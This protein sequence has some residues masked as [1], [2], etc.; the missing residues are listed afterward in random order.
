MKREPLRERWEAL[1]A[2]QQG[3]IAF[4]LLGVLTFLLNLGPFNQPL[5]RSIVYGVIE[6]GLLTAL[7]LVATAQEK[8]R[9]RP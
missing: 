7:V 8:A 1:S 4:P 5:G 6:G 3:L 2:W 9:R